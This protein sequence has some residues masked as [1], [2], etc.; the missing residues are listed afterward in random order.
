MP[1]PP[2]LV[3][4]ISPKEGP[5]KYSHQLNENNLLICVNIKLEQ[6]LQFVE[7]IWD[8]ELMI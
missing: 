5:R 3:T 8:L 6:K 2:P 1:P 7:K 4:G